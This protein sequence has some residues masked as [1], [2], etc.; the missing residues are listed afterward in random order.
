MRVRL[1]AFRRS[2]VY[3]LLAACAASVLTSAPAVAAAAPAPVNLGTAAAFSVLAGQSVTNTGPTTVSGDLGVSPGS[4]VTGFPPGIVLGTTHV[5]D[6]AAATAQADLTTAY[7]DAAGRAPTAPVSGD[8]GGQT[9]NA[10]V[11]NSTSTL[12]LTGTV[13]LDA[14]G[15]PNAV[16]IFQVGS[17]LTT[18]SSSVVNLVNGAQACNVFW[19]VGSSATLG[20]TSN[21]R[22]T[23]M[24]LTSI[25]VN[26][27]ATLTGRAL[28]RNGSVSLDTD[29]ITTTICEPIPLM[30]VPGAA[31]G[32]LAVLGFGAFRLRRRR[33]SYR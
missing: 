13:T 15:D 21:F 20:T 27:G 14:Q 19:Q 9:F 17:A 10:G 6:A 8:I 33:R 5:A 7:N 23:I 26:T 32:V 18:A 25:T 1:T 29:S 11:Y 4:S 28:A 2:A 22:G 16:F 24:A 30:A 3:L 12:G 31:A